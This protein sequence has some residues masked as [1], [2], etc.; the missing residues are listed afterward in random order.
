MKTLR[1]SFALIAGIGLL[2]FADASAAL[3]QSRIDPTDTPT[4]SAGGSGWA[5]ELGRVIGMGWYAA[6][7][8]LVIVIFYMRYAPRFA[9]DEESAR[10]V[11]ADRVVPG[12]PAPRRTV[13]LSQ[14]VPIVVQPPSLPAAMA[15]PAPT[16]AA[17]APA[18]SAPAAPAPV[19]AVAAPAPAAP[20]AEAPAQAAP[21]AAPSAPAP[22]A[23][24][25][26]AEVSLDQETFDKTLEELLAQGTDRR[27][28]EGKARRAAMIAARKKAAGEA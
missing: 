18:A 13:D 20:V 21:P 17:P 6:V 24:E 14:A 26:H 23:A 9:K 8:V 1:R 22:V 3:A 4:Q 27:I 5:Y 28:A 25:P 12:E 10:V 2:V 19:A 11:H 16:P 7:L 15:A